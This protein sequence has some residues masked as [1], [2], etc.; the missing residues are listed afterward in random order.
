MTGSAARIKAS[1]SFTSLLVGLALILSLFAAT[2]SSA[3]SRGISVTTRDKK[4]IKLYSGYNALVIG[5]GQYQQWPKLPGAKKDA[6]EVAATLKKMGFNVTTVNDPTSDRLRDLLRSLPYELGADPKAALLIYY[7]GHG[8]TE[9]LADGSTL[10]YIVP[11]DCPLSQKDPAGFARKAVSMSEVEA[12]ALRIKSRHVMMVFDSCFSGSLFA[13]VRA[14]PAYISEKVA[15]PSRQFITA[16]N[17]NE[18]VPD[19]SIFKQLFESGIQGEADQDRDGY[20]TGSELGMYLQNRVVQYSNRAQHPQFGSINNPKLDK[21]DFVFVVKSKTPTTTGDKAGGDAGSK[22]GAYSSEIEAERQRLEAERRQL[23]EMKKLYE[24]RRK[25]AKELASLESERLKQERD[26]LKKELEDAKRKPEPTPEPQAQPKSVTPPPVKAQKGFAALDAKVT[27]LRLYEGG[28][29]IPPKKSRQYRTSFDAGDLRYLFWELNLKYPA[30]GKTVDFKVDAYCYDSGGKLYYHQK[31]DSYAKA[32][33]KSSWVTKG[34]G[35]RTPGKAWRPGRYRL[36]VHAEG[37][38]VASESFTVTSS[39]ASLPTRTPAGGAKRG[40]AGLDAS[41]ENLR[42]FEGGRQAPPNKQRRFST[43]FESDHTKFLY[44]QLSLKYPKTDSKVDF[45]IRAACYKPDGTL[46]FTQNM[47]AYVQPGWTSSWHA[48]GWGNTAA[49]KAW[50]PGRYKVEL[51][52]DGNR[53]AQGHF[54]VT[55]G[56]KISKASLD[57]RSGSGFRSLRARVKSLRLFESDYNQPA[58]DQRSFGT[59]FKASS[60]RFLNWQL[61]L[62]YPKPGRRVDFKITAVCYRQNG[63]VQ[64]KQAMDG[65]ANADWTSSWHSMG[66]G[67]RALGKAWRPGNYRLELSID[68]ER[69]A[70]REFRVVR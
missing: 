33:W 52:V 4:Q 51:S 21:G 22:P 39:K 9:V 32:T 1:A 13:M 29:D 61:D 27:S 41:V 17:E 53:V 44:W 46:L 55:G 2:P 43:S 68:G 23:A 15:R 6:S 59:N 34:W 14:E 50:A 38:K 30:P 63:S 18:Q 10:G 26:Q 11:V 3:T 67:N 60:T 45:K 58:K 12:L 69:V 64:F 25:V 19:K 62:G 56:Q 36:E 66:W 40:F 24:E 42:F 7:A 65:H 57:D 47:S 31:I 49:G 8:A 54:E 20:V 37:K 48:M 5:V 28:Y 70:S 16:G 35:N